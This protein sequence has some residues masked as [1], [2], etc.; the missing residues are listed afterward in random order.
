MTRKVIHEH[1]IPKS[2]TV[3]LYAIAIALTLNL[4]KPFVDVS[5]AQA[6]ETEFMLL[7]YQLN[8]IREKVDEVDSKVSDVWST[9]INNG[10]KLTRI[11]ST[12]N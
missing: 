9:V 10:L 4:A 6:D 12:L 2:L 8:K 11:Q 5:T 1:K 3:A 7:D